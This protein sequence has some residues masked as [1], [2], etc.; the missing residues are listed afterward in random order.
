MKTLK[1]TIKEMEE[2]GLVIDRVM[3][4]QDGIN[5]KM[6]IQFKKEV[7]DKYDTRN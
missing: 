4:A 3:I 2:L 1:E 6:Q 5:T 7:N